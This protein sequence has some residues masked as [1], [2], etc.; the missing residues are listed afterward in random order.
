MIFCIL[1]VT[2]TFHESDFELKILDVLC[3]A[4]T[5]E[6]PLQAEEIPWHAHFELKFCSTP[7]TNVHRSVITFLFHIPLVAIICDFYEG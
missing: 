4:L 7:Q 1:L 3:L 2:P 5:H 6:S